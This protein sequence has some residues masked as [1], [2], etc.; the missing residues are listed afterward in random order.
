MEDIK[1]SVRTA[2]NSDIDNKVWYIRDNEFVEIDIISLM[3]DIDS[4]MKRK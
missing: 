1:I 4:S 3:K 2:F